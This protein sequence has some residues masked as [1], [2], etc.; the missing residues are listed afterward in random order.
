M[1]KLLNIGFFLIFVFM[2]NYVS[3]RRLIIFLIESFSL[4]FSCEN[5]AVVDGLTRVN[6]IMQDKPDSALAIIR[7]LDT[8]SIRT[9]KWKAMYALSKAIALDKNYI[10]TTDASFLGSAKEYYLR[11]GSPEEK[12][13]FHYY[14]GR[15]YFNAANYSDALASYTDALKHSS[16]VDD[17]RLK[18]QVCAA[19]GDTYN[20]TYC[21]EDNLKYKKMAHDCFVAHGDSLDIDYSRINLAIAMHNCRKDSQSDSLLQLISSQKLV[22]RATVLL[23]ANEIRRDN[24]DF[25][26]VISLFSDVIAHGKGLSVSQYY[27]YSY[28]LASKGEQQASTSILKHLS[29]YPESAESTWWKYRIAKLHNDYDGALNYLEQY[30]GKRDSI[31]RAQL[32]QS[33]YKTLG[34]YYNAASAVSDSKAQKARLHAYFSITIS[35]LLLLIAFLVIQR[36]RIRLI[37]RN[38]FLISQ[39]DEA[40][41]MIECLKF[42]KDNERIDSEKHI[43]ELNDEKEQLRQ[44]NRSLANRYE[45]LKNTSDSKLSRLRYDFANLYQSQFEEI[46]ELFNKGYSVE[47]MSDSTQKAYARKYGSIISELYNYPDK[48]KDFEGRINRSLDGIMTKLRAD[49]PEFS[50]DSFRLASYVIVGFDACTLSFLLNTS[51]NNVWVKKHRLTQKILSKDSPN[52]DLYRLFFNLR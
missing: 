38:E 13:R 36:H 8:N 19:I 39:R 48:Q 43:R 41:R 3:M 9:G 18:G 30:S 24:P 50:E 49:F 26:K 47:K 34:Q 40:G 37:Q 25:D 7:Q 23:A 15:I 21:N 14:V 29:L 10:D 20:R 42:Q 32:S 27:E 6:D 5:R 17:Y 31:V 33:L 11:H 12:M 45:S 52:E 1:G 35:I 28:A 16:E 44:A 2:T 4:L 51:K 22:D 46:N